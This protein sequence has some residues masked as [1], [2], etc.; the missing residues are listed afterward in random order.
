MNAVSL[1]PRGRRYTVL[2][3]GARVRHWKETAEIFRRAEELAAAGRRAA[4]ATVVRIEGSAYR[5]PGARLLV[6]DDG[7]TPPDVRNGIGRE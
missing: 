7:T 1:T 2:V 4:L 6:E 5:R 3:P